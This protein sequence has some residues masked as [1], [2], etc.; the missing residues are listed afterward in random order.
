VTLDLVTRLHLQHQQGAQ[1]VGS[2]DDRT[3][4][5][6]NLHFNAVSSTIQTSAGVLHSPPVIV[7]LEF[8]I[9]NQRVSEPH[10]IDIYLL[11]LSSIANSRA[12]LAHYDPENPTECSTA[13]TE[14]SKPSSVS[15][16][17]TLHS[18][19]NTWHHH[20]ST[21]HHTALSCSTVFLV[22]ATIATHNYLTLTAN[23]YR[24]LTP[25]FVNTGIRAVLSSH[26]A[27]HCYIPL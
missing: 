12:T 19:C 13:Y 24:R 1:V 6:P 21:L 17:Y 10:S 15:S 27:M 22:F 2:D 3:C 26:D 9:N 7:L 14:I 5:Y 4:S 11:P 23:Q 16:K 25:Q 20:T 18:N 8:L